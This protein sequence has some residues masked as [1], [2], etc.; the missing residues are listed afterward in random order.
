MADKTDNLFTRDLMFDAV[1]YS[2][3]NIFVTRLICTGERRSL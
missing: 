2:S 3:C 1:P